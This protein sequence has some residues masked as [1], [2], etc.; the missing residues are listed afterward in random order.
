MAGPDNDEIPLLGAI[1]RMKQYRSSVGTL[2][3]EM[4]ALGDMRVVLATRL[5]ELR[6]QQDTNT[7]APDAFGMR[8]QCLFDLGSDVPDN[9]PMVH[10]VAY[11]TYK[12]KAFRFLWVAWAS[13]VGL[14]LWAHVHDQDPTI[15][16][17][18]R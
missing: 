7:S 9:C 12:T 18:G 5:L 11:E 15:L 3:D 14:R 8:R 16:K 17:M 4:K 2:I 10:A 13:H 1:E 6:Q